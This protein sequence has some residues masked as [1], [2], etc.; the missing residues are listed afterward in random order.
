MSATS[1]P[2]PIA[3]PRGAVLQVEKLDYFVEYRVRGFD[4]IQKA[5]PYK[6]QEEADEHKRDIAGFEGVEGAHI[7]WRK[8]DEQEKG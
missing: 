1:R 7:T 8:K 2:K 4:G 3:Q 5:G 6:S